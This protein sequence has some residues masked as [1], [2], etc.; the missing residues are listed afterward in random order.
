MKRYPKIYRIEIPGYPRRSKRYLTSEEI[1]EL[2]TGPVVVE[3]KLDGKL[4][5]L[6]DEGYAIFKENLKR[7]HTVAY[8]QLPK[9]E[10]GLDIWDYQ[11]ECFLG[12]S[13]KQV[14]FGA[15]DI[16]TPPILFEGVVKGLGQLFDL[17]GIESAFGALRIEGIVI[18][19]Y[20]RELFGKIVDPLFDREI[21]ETGHYL[22]RPYI[23]N[24][25]GF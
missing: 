17:L 6:E 13:E 21:D 1:D 20:G 14:V 16:P 5:E 19:N 7:K 9:W 11:Q 24:R 3:E 23:R 8:T 12:L 4:I 10:V 2:L 22:D 18:K 15:L 25:L